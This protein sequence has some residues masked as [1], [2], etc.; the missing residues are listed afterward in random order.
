MNPVIFILSA[1]IAATSVTITEPVDGEVYDGD[2]LLLEAIVEN[3]NQLPD[4]VCYSL[5][6]GSMMDVPRLNTDWYTYMADSCRTGCSKAQA[7][8][9]SDI[10][11]TRAISGDYHEFVSPVIVDGRVY[12]SSEM[13]ETTY[14]LDAASG[15]EIWR[16]EDIGDR[17][18]DAVHVEDGRVYLASDSIWCLDALTGE[19]IW[20]YGDEVGYGFSGPPVPYGDMVFAASEYVYALDIATGQEVWRT[21]TEI[22]T[23]SAMTAW[24]NLLFVPELMGSQSG[25]YAL[26]TTDGGIVW[27]Y[28][29]SG[30]WDSSPCIVDSLLYIG[31]AGD[32]TMYAF[33]PFTG[34]V[35]WELP[36]GTVES[37]PACDGDRVIFGAYGYVYAVDPLNGDTEWEFPLPDGYILH[38][39]P[40]I[41]D[42]LVFWG[43]FCVSMEDSLALIHAV[44][45]C[46]GQEI[47]SYQTDGGPI[48]IQ[49]S[50]AITDGVMYIPATDSLLYAFGDGLEYTYREEFFYADVGPNEL[51]VASFDEGAVAA[52]DTISFTVTQEGVVASPRNRLAFSCSPNP[53]RSATIVSFDLPEPAST[54]VTVYDLSGRVVRVLCDSRLARG[55]H[56][57]GW[58]GSAEDGQPLSTGLYIC[59]IAAGALQQT[60]GVCLLR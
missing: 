38:G 6:A 49:S 4:S 17:I 12:Y 11:W 37:T 42:G 8:H 36:I 10:L 40:G 16:F 7:P 34:D 43:D 56:S 26:D 27:S 48:G 58:D 5:N 44:D 24:C 25:L 46:T 15:E 22:P 45:I 31:S 21:A 35:V 39:S 29:S 60:T 32:E 20:A 51:I 52:A 57:I 23:A 14:C 28:E 33:D 53:F 50:P 2:W 59:R 30:F 19:R 55:Q 54:T 9:N 18:D 1:L 13:Y 41:A 3:D 47:W